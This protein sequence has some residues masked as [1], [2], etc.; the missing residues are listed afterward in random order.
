MT[1]SHSQ[2]AASTGQQALW[3]YHQL[4]PT[5]PA[6]NMVAARELRADLDPATLCRAFARVVEHCETLHCGYRE[7]NGVV[8][9]YHPGQVR[10]N[11]SVEHNDSLDSKGVAD[12]IEQHADQPFDLAAADICRLRLLQCQGRLYLC[13]AAHHISGDFLSVEWMLKLTFAAYHA[14]LTGEPLVLPQAG[15]YFDWLDEQRELQAEHKL[16][17]AAAYWRE[18]LTGNPTALTLA[19]DRPRPRTPGFA[20]GEVELLLDQA[21]SDQLRQLAEAHGVSLYVVLATLFQVFMH[22]YTGQD[23][24]LIGTPTMDRHKARYK[25][26][27]GFTLNSLPLRSVSAMPRAWPTACATP[28]SN[29]AK[30]CAIAATRRRS[31]NRRSPAAPVPLH[32][33][34]HAKP[35]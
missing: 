21:R 2:H 31:C 22:R 6:Y 15:L 3:Q 33:D 5:S 11:A 24:F 1:T 25:E 7:Q 16:G 20:G 4:N 29:C 10:V 30:P 26:L 14:E 17:A 34:L 32:D 18:Q 12:W 35:A 8:F 27:I 13:M 9:M 19:A 23:D 28:P